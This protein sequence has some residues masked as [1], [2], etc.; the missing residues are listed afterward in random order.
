MAFN[1]FEILAHGLNL[2][3]RDITSS[4]DINAVVAG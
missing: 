1:A 3:R 4:S 2:H